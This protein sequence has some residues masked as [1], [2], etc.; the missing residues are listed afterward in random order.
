MIEQYKDTV[1]FSRL[2]MTD[3]PDLYRQITAVPFRNRRA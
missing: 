1:F 2:F 3:Y